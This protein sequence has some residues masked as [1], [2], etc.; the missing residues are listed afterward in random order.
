[1]I[2]LWESLLSRLGIRRGGGR[3]FFALE[4]RL[5]TAL[6]EL[7]EQEQRPVAEVYADLLAEGLA[8]RQTYKELRQ[9]WLVL[10]P[11]EQDVT[12]FTCLR[13]TNRQIAGLSRKRLKRLVMLNNFALP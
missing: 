9:R 4:A 6:T 11:R 2:K 13:Y 1:M 8:Q 3:R 7:A 5:Y 12:A 10:S